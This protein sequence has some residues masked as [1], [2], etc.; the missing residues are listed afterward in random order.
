MGFEGD[1][2]KGIEVLLPPAAGDGEM[3]GWRVVGGSY[4][5]C[6]RHPQ[7]R[8]PS[9]SLSIFRASIEGCAAT[10]TCFCAQCGVSPTTR[11]SPELLIAP[12]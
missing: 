6:I 9:P 11:T 12:H 5:S 7:I 4:Q 3:R 10:A 8:P 2:C 1:I